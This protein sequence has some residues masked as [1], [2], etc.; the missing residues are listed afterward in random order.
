MIKEK[1]EIFIYYLYNDFQKLFIKPSPL[2]L[3]EKWNSK[4]TCF[5]Y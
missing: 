3:D 4:L 2:F 5:I 1:F